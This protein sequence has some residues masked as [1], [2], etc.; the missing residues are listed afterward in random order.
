MFYIGSSTR[1]SRDFGENLV[2]LI[3]SWAEAEVDA[4]RIRKTVFIE[5]QAVPE[6]MELDLY[7]AQA[8]HALFY[9][10]SQCI[11]TARLVVQSDGAGKIGRMAVLSPYR[12]QGFGGQLLGALIGFGKSQGIARFVLNAQMVAIPFYEKLGFQAHGPVYDEAGIPHRSMML[13][14]NPTAP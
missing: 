7:D 4:Y 12:R 6:E 1:L 8:Q 11:G 13:I 5:E 10:N 2:I 9:Q 14:L 3:K